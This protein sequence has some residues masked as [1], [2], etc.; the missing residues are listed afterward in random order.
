MDSIT[1]DGL[2]LKIAHALKID[3]RASFTAIGE[4]LDVSDQTVARR[5]QRMRSAGA[6]RV[7]GLLG[8]VAPGPDR[9]FVR[10]R[11]VP[12]AAQSIA[13]ALAR[14]TDTY[15]IQ[16][17]AGGA[18]VICVTAPVSQASHEALLLQKLPRTPRITDINAYQLLRSYEP[19]PLLFGERVDGLTAAQA[20]LLRPPPD[21]LPPT[22]LTSTDRAIVDVLG[23]DGRASLAELAAT[24]GHPESTVRRRLNALRRN[25]CLRFDIDMANDL[26]GHYAHSILWLTVEPR[27][28]RAAARAM[29]TY[30][31]VNFLAAVSG[32]ANLMASVTCRNGAALYDFIADRVGALDGVRQASTAPV[33]RIIKRHG[34]P[35]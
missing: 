4:V 33:Q 22:P 35:W 5:Y 14:R 29:L 16:L 3:G 27:E 12:D 8:V 15:W 19:D 10:I 23:R 1:L 31:E 30:S 2:D 21:D 13:E 7:V 9:W 6:L 25:G 24:T 11:C 28:L 26:T 32:S 17:A 20:D 34:Q 18:E